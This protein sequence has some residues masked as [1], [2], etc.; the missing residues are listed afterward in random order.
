[1]GGNLFKGKSRRYQKDEYEALVAE[2]NP[3][4]EKLFTKYNVC[5]AFKDKDSFGDMDVVGV[6]SPCVNFPT[7]V[8]EVT[9]CDEVSKNGNQVSFLYKEFQVDLVC[10]SETDYPMAKYYY[11]N[12]DRGNFVGKLAH[13][14]GLKYGHDGLWLKVRENESHLLRE[15]LLT[16]DPKVADAFLDVEYREE[17]DSFDDMFENVVASKYFNVETYD[18]ENN[19]HVSR[20]RDAKRPNYTKFREYAAKMTDRKFF[21][22]AKDKSVHLPLVFA[23]FPHAEKEYHEAK[24]EFR[25][26]TLFRTKLNGEMVAELTGLKDKELGMM[27][28]RLREVMN[29]DN[30]EHMT[31]EEVR[32][33]A[34][35][36]VKVNFYDF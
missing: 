25:K 15:V 13:T 8:I 11:G 34:E 6:V 7:R 18:D 29:P 23:A 30:T 1:M 9:N 22:Y 26:L 36:L 35:K 33:W 4:F 19:N 16:N 31:A 5:P 2:L 3:A 24:E 32:N 28:K 17:F 20:V 10:H 12:G 14:L 27:M 21:P